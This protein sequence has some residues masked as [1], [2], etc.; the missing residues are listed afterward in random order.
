M[1]DSSHMISFFAEWFNGHWVHD[2]SPFLGPHWG[3]IGIR[4][5]G[6]SYM[7]GFLTGW[8]LLV[9]YA[10]AG[11]S[12]VPAAK[13][14]DLMVAIVFGVLI[15]GRIG[16]FVLYEPESLFRNPLQLLRVWDGGMASH[17]GFIGVALALAWFGRSQRIPVVHLGDIAASTAAAGL[18]FGRIANFING[19]LWG[20]VSNVPWAVIFPKSATPGMQGHLAFPRHPSQLYEAAL[21][22]VV[23]FAFA[24]WRFWRSDIVRTQPGR[25]C[26][27][28]LI[29]YA[30]LRVI[31]ESFREPDA[32]PLLGL[33]RGV[34]YSVFIVIAG[35]IL[36][37]HGRRAQPIPLQGPKD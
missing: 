9:R 16:Y 17:G 2:W 4:Y 22:G 3:N 20:K 12:L 25:L 1:R 33:S 23:L 11:R 28:F 14:A 26:G 34:F 32:P 19:E 7:L 13:V 36:I 24:Q 15:G 30:I 35:I 29:A 5:Y 31:G 21:E 27:E 18:F 8:W 37:V 6:L 10:R